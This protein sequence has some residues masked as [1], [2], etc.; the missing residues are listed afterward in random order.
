MNA[1]PLTLTNYGSG[2]GSL[3]FYQRPEGILWKKRHGCINPRKKVLNSKKV[4]FKVRCL[5]KLSVIKKSKA[6][7]N[8]GIGAEAGAVIWI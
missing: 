7:N 6:R 5:L 4:I 1:Y 8:V 2:Y 3:P